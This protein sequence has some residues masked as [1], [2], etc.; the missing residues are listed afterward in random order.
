[1]CQCRFINCNKYTTLLGDVGNSRRLCMCG[2]RRYT[3][4]LYLPLSVSTNLKRL[5]NIKSVNKRGKEGSHLVFCCS[6]FGILIP[7]GK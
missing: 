3:G 5:Y 1:M 6:L 7:K 4:N 2:G